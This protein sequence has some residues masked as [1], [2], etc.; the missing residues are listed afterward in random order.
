MERLSSGPHLRSSFQRIKVFEVSKTA[1]PRSCF[2]NSIFVSHTHNKLERLSSGPHRVR[3]ALPSGDRCTQFSSFGET[4]FLW[5]V[6]IIYEFLCKIFPSKLEIEFYSHKKVVSPKL[7]NCA[8]L[9]IVNF[10]CAKFQQNQGT[11]FFTMKSFVKFSQ[12]SNLKLNL[13]PQESCFTKTRKLS[14]N[15]IS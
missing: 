4:T 2:E 5:V 1:D 9:Y 15:Y 8:H 11:L 14:T 13:F 6:K 3:A 10:M 12:L 7:E